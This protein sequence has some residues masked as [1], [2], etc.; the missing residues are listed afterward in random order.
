LKLGFFAE[1]VYS[2]EP[3]FTN[4]TS[5]ILASPAFEPVSEMQTLYLPDF[6]AHQYGGLGLR[7]VWMIKN[8][9]DFRLEGYV[10]Q[11]YRELVKTENLETKYGKELAKQYYIG[12]S[13][14]V[15]HSPLGPISLGL[16]YYHERKN[17]FS[18]L[19]HFGYI[20]F[21]KSATE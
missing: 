19:F 13:T 21:S 2:N 4:Y 17:P 11:P 5:T 20:I 7:N 16:N 15:F 8:N 3:F 9:L 1:A 6:H 12:S 10:F 14:M 18:L